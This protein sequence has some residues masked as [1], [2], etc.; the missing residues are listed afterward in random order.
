MA[1]MDETV[2]DPYIAQI[3]CKVCPTPDEII[4]E[5]RD[6]CIIIRICTLHSEVAFY[7]LYILVGID[8]DTSVGVWSM[9]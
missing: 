1:F 2:K 9:T 5:G 4:Y 8:G 3:I 7:V 6:F